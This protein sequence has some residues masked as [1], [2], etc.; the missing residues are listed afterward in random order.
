[1]ASERD[2]CDPFVEWQHR[3]ER[4]AAGALVGLVA[5]WI[6]GASLILAML[7]VE[8]GTAPVSGT[9]FV[10]LMAVPVITSAAACA[11]PAVRHWAGYFLPGATVGWGL[12]YLSFLLLWLL[13]FV[14]QR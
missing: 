2:P 10:L 4:S 13:A 7:E 11:V 6:T 12:G 5:A 9:D 14:S 8:S 1:M 3:P